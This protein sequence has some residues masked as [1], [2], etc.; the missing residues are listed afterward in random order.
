MYVCYWRKALWLTKTNNFNA[1]MQLVLHI[2]AVWASPWHWFQDYEPTWTFSESEGVIKRWFCRSLHL[3]SVKH[4]IQK[5]RSELW[6][7]TF[8]CHLLKSSQHPVSHLTWRR[9]CWVSVQ[10]FWGQECW[11]DKRDMT[12]PSQDEQGLGLVKAALLK[13]VQLTI[14]Q[15]MR[16]MWWGSAAVINLYS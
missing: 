9:S 10:G 5:H 11:L 16:R 1:D 12:L 15:M 7:P 6:F 4:L 3:C 14:E 2:R 13:I 8:T